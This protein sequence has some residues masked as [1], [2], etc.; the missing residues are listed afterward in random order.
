[1]PFEFTSKRSKLDRL[2]GSLM[3]DRG[4]FDA[5]WRELSDY[6]MPRR[7]RF[8]AG[9]R[10]KGDKRNQNIINSTGR[11]AVRTLQ[12]G[13]HAGLTSPA[14]PWMKL[15][16]PDQDLNSFGPVREWLHVV[17][18]RMLQLFAVTNLYNVL[19][20][21]YGDMGLFGTGCM[22]ILEDSD[23]LFRAYAYPTGSYWLGHDA[24]GQV[25]TY[26]REY[27][28]TVAQLVEQFGL[29]ANGRDIDWSRFTTTVKHLWDSNQYESPVDVT[30]VV[31]PNR[32]A[33]ADRLEAKYLPWASCWFE[34]GGAEPIFLRESGF[35][36]FPILAP[37]WD[38]TGEDTYGTDCPGMT[39][40]GD[41]KQ[42]QAMERTK[43][44]ALQKV[45]NPPLVGPSSLRTQKTSLLPGDITYVDAREGMQGL[46]SIHEI[47]LNLEH[48]SY[49]IER[50]EHRIKRAFFEDLFLMLATSDPVR[51]SQP[52]TAREIDERH[53]EKLLALG[54]VLERTNDELLDP[55]IDRVFHL[56]GQVPGM[57]PD[58]P[59]EIA[60][61]KLRVEYI[62]ILS[63]AQKM[64]GVTAQDRFLMSTVPLLEAFPI[65]GAKVNIAQIVDNY[66]EML[67]V[68]PR[69]IRS[70]D[71]AEAMLA[72]QQEAAQA[73]AES[74]QMLNAAKATQAMGTT[75]VGADSALDRIL[76]SAGSAL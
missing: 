60:G 57:L 52:P 19:P 40:L 58:A 14:R 16:V 37:R 73:Q 65:I 26:L 68:D 64:I 34:T 28:L 59:P 9:D 6:F 56:M 38:V 3:Q 8:W 31:Y 61:A 27:Q 41:A 74:E 66:G 33:T 18:Q 48:L 54:P 17:T 15:S 35:R 25:N 75:P 71:E 45:V 12:S 30:W 62:S 1:M 24:R 47:S 49:D 10:N 53:E 36:T 21:V 50:V 44:Q 20:Q 70:T 5:H 32:E 22:S 13:L 46:R 51:G 42:L 69:T 23:D 63:Q 72:A 67:G 76:E 39:A 2:R 29:A 4:T 43:G 55:L 7:T 11:Y